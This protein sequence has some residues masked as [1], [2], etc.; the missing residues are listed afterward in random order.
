M[1]GVWTEARTVTSRT[2]SRF[3][4]IA[5]RSGRQVRCTS[6][7]G[8]GVRIPRSGWG[9]GNWIGFRVVFLHGST[10]PIPPPRG[11]RDS[12]RLAFRSATGDEQHTRDG[13]HRPNSRTE[14]K[15]PHLNTPKRSLKQRQLLS[16]PILRNKVRPEATGTTTPSC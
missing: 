8:R 16:V 5:R 4:I 11:V 15:K 10:V 1:T 7:R 12:G 13:I 9:H 3:E 2:L 6:G 14:R